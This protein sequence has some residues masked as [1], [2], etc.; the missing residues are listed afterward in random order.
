[1]FNKLNFLIL[2][3][4]SQNLETFYEFQNTFRS[5]KR[6]A[7]IMNDMYFEVKSFQNNFG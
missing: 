7:N 6:L 3:Q 1:M 5:T 2:R 4:E